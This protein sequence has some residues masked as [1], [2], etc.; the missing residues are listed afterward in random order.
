MWVE[1]H[2]G[3][4]KHQRPGF[5][6]GHW[7]AEEHRRE[8]HDEQRPGVAEHRRDPGPGAAGTQKHGAEGEEGAGRGE[9][10]HA[11]PQP[12][13]RQQWLAEDQDQAQQSGAAQCG[14]QAREP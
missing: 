8:H 6:A 4:A 2:A 10:Q 13:R 7:L 1:A 5:D 9:G 3:K 11:R 12:A 14:P